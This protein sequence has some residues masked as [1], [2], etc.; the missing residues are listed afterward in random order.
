MFRRV[1]FWNSFE[2]MLECSESLAPIDPKFSTSN[3]RIE[4]G[5][6]QIFK[7]N[8]P[9]PKELESE[10]IRI[11]VRLIRPLENEKTL[12]EKSGF[13]NGWILTRL[14]CAFIAVSK[15]IS[16]FYLQLWGFLT[17][18]WMPLP[19]PQM[20]P[21]LLLSWR[22]FEEEDQLPFHFQ[23]WMNSIIGCNWL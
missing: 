20:P 11:R 4:I 2:W 23:Q 19:P 8:N 12:L 10:W 17:A 5:N 18:H 14:V 22:S 7:S 6:R 9:S 21:P 16:C 3:R 15:W 1:S 13:A